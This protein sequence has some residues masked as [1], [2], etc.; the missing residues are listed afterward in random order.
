M[1]NIHEISKIGIG[2]YRIG[3]DKRI[4]VFDVLNYAIESGINIIDTA[5]NYNLG[6]SEMIIGSVL[7]NQNRNSVF[8]VTKVGYIQG[9]DIEQVKNIENH[10]Q[11][12]LS[13]NSFYSL[14]TNFV[15]YQLEQ[16]LKRLNT[17]YIDCYMLHNPEYYFNGN[18]E[19][20]ENIIFNSF[21]LLEEKVKKGYIRYYGISSNSLKTLPLHKIIKSLS[22]FPGFKFLQFPY[23][24]VE[25]NNNFDTENGKISIAELKKNGINILSNRPLNTVYENKV[26]RLSDCSFENIHVHYEEEG[27][28]FE[29][30]L[31]MIKRKLYDI[32]ED[33]ELENYFP[34]EF[35]IK[36]RKNIANP[37]AIDSAIISYLIPF[38]EALNL[39]NGE[40]YYILNKL[41]NYWIIFS[42]NN[43][44]IRLNFL[45]KQLY[46]EGV[47]KEADHRDLS[48]ILAQNYIKSGIDTVLMGLNRKEY[49]DKIKDII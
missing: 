46:K 40:V 31:T 1:V 13:D 6:N 16:S 49:I 8:I 23:N 48:V 29:D 26:L 3:Q 17:D 38:L 15:S 19:D 24:I 20:L 22:K 18:K 10:S 35:F 32:N 28:L 30:F 4:N 47:L 34:I 44:Q 27:K 5:P 37:E 39:K 9:E 11:L 42:K 41:R 21:S 45:K 7:K 36:N 25:R 2:T 14:S 43:N 12:F 33:P